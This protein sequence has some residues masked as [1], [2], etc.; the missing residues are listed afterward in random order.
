MR[1]PLALTP[2]NKNL[3]FCWA[4]LFNSAITRWYRNPWR[5]TSR[6]SSNLDLITLQFSLSF[7]SFNG[8]AICL[9]FW[10]QFYEIIVT[11]NQH[12]KNPFWNFHANK[13][14]V[15]RRGIKNKCMILIKYVN[16][17]RAWTFHDNNQSS[18]RFFTSNRRTLYPCNNQS[19]IQ[20]W[21]YV[22][23]NFKIGLGPILGP[24]LKY[25]IPF[26]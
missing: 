8:L 22:V 17:C 21:I 18:S 11:A 26:E 25:D 23:H 7:S 16:G 3:L 20:K 9:F 24:N 12:S 14:Y 10:C 13:T 1:S 6:R 2:R 5:W 15:I 19:K 4:S